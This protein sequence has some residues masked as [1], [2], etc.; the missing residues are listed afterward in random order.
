MAQYS[1]W[2]TPISIQLIGE[3]KGENGRVRAV[4]GRYSHQKACQTSQNWNKLLHVT[5]ISLLVFSDTNARNYSASRV[6]FAVVC[7]R[8]CNHAKLR[9]IDL[10]KTGEKPK[11][12]KVCNCLSHN[13]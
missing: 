2:W 4:V 13:T 9:A 11:R 3:E 7:R 6:G 5:L 12:M 1:A 10:E 8:K